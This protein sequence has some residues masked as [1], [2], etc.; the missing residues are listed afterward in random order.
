MLIYELYYEHCEYRELEN[1]AEDIFSDVLGCDKVVHLTVGSL[2]GASSKE[3]FDSYLLHRLAD[4]R[5]FMVSGSF[6]FFLEE[7]E[8]RLLSSVVGKKS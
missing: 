8:D 4:S 5:K 3:L 6:F 2:I 7:C 1:I